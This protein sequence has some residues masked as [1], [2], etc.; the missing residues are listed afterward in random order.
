MSLDGHGQQIGMRSM[1]TEQDRLEAYNEER[2]EQWAHDERLNER[3]RESMTSKP[4]TLTEPEEWWS[5][6]EAQAKKEGKTLS[7]WLGDAGMEKLPAKVRAM[8]PERPPANRPK[9]EE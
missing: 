2:Y 7:E 6:F 4:K 8:L 1:P 3:D 5:A 9:K